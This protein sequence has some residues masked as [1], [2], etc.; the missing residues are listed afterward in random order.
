MRTLIFLLAFIIGA[1]SPSPKSE[2]ESVA[3]VEATN[4][5]NDFTLASLSGDWHM[6]TQQ[7]NEWVLFYPCDADNTMVSIHT[8]SIMIGW[9]QDATVGKIESWSASKGSLALVVND[10]YSTNTY[11]VEKTDD[12]LTQWWLWEDAEGP[13]YFISGKDIAS[14]PVIKQPCKE[15]WEDCDDEVGN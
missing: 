10:S 9:G 5:S 1:C 6:V 12:G 7:N 13:S 14:Y 11:R 3:E 2:D 15:C 8:D 4:S